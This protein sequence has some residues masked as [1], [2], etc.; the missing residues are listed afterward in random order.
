MS[1]AQTYLDIPY[2]QWGDVTLHLDIFLPGHA[3][4]PLPLV[5]WVPGGGWRNCNKA[6]KRTE[7]LTRHGFASA[8]IN[9]RVSG[10]AS[11]PANIQ[12]CKAAIRWMRAHAEPYGIDPDRIGVWGSSAGG[13][14]VALLGTTNGLA[15]IEGS[16]NSDG[17]SSDVQAVCDFCGPSDL[18]RIAEPE[19]RRDHEVLYDVTA[20]YLGGPVEERDELA[21]LMS[22]FHHAS[23][24]CPPMLIGHGEL[25]PTVPVEESIIL[26]EALQQ[27]G[28]DV[29]LHIVKGGG[30]GWDWNQTNGTVVEFFKRTLA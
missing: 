28:T 3:Q 21:R 16:G 9:Y 22:P 26:H 13:H 12:D 14:L 20:Q 5:V 23:A 25:D 8:A 10:V 11:A 30:H 29:T 7:F 24:D 15:E 2:A 18:T 6:G 4:G 27:A 17:W 1:D 19:V